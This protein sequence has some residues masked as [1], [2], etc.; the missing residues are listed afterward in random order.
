EEVLAGRLPADSERHHPRRNLLTRAVLGDPVAADI[1][2]HPWKRGDAVLLCSDGVWE[3]LSDADLGQL[4]TA[5]L[6][7]DEVAEA[8]CS[9]ALAAGSRD[10]VTA[11]VARLVR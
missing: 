10:N 8:I 7:T 2:S 9:A 1:G 3:P 4:T 11:V 6:V 5:D